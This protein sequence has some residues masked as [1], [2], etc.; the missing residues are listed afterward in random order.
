MARSAR[1]SNIEMRSDTPG[2][3]EIKLA[4]R[5][6]TEKETLELEKQ[7]GFNY[8]QAIRELASWY[9][10]YCSSHSVNTQPTHLHYQAVKHTSM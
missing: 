10:C 3:A 6:S 5:P 7:I 1:S 8:G 2:Q 9:D 4:T